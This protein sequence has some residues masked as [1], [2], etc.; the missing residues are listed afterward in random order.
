MMKNFY[1]SVEIAHRPN[2]PYIPDHPYRVLITGSS[3]SGMTN[4]LLKTS[5]TRYWQNLFIC[6][7]SV[8]IK[9]SIAYQRKKEREQ[10]PKALIGYSQ[11]INDIMKI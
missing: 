11:T 8:Q 9:V 10:N 3:G 6:Q 2:W 4:A 7:G 1:E 5:T